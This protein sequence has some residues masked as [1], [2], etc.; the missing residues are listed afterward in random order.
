MQ[1][2]ALATL[3]SPEPTGR[4]GG[5]LWVCGFVGKIPW[6]FVF[7]KVVEYFW[8]YRICDGFSFG[9]WSF[10]VLWD[11]ALSKV[12]RILSAPGKPQIL[13][14]KSLKQDDVSKPWWVRGTIYAHLS[15]PQ[16][17]E[18][19]SQTAWTFQIDCICGFG[20]VVYLLQ[21]SRKMSR[22]GSTQS[23]V[24]GLCLYRF[25]LKQ[26]ARHLSWQG[27]EVETTPLSCTGKTK[28]YCTS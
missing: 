11:L 15:S 22:S 12:A 21:D 23:S 28:M 24:V 14:F 18:G 25:G 1:G 4:E 8:I 9:L 10:F 27:S 3:V 7:A 5:G 20:S 13:D 26:K 6:V 2:A 16:I 19:S 17:L